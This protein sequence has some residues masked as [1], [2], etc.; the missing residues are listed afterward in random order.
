MQTTIEIPQAFSVRDEHEFYPFQHLLARLNP[1]LRVVQIATGVHIHGGCT[2][3]WGLVYQD[4]QPPTKED[5][6]AALKRAGYDFTHNGP[7]QV[8]VLKSCRPEAKAIPA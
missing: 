2:V 4:R 8:S 7:S 1:E 5:V 3:L 6:E